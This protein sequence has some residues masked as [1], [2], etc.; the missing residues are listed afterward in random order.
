MI[1][2]IRTLLA[3]SA[4]LA[5]CVSSDRAEVDVGT[6][7]AWR[8]QSEDDVARLFESLRASTP[9]VL[10]VSLRPRADYDALLD[11]QGSVWSRLEDLGYVGDWFLMPHDSLIDYFEFEERTYYVRGVFLLDFTVIVTTNVPNLFAQMCWLLES[12]SIRYQIATGQT[13]GLGVAG[14]DEKRALD[15]LLA[16]EIVMSAIDE[17]LAHAY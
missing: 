16:D 3:A 2:L 7:T 11:L 9:S 12:S 17:G 4:A 14:A 10:E 1:A 15:I 8:I 5:G 6:Q 13:L